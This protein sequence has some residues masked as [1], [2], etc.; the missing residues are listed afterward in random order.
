MKQTNIKVLLLLLLLICYQC[1]ASIMRQTKE[2]HT[3]MHP[4]PSEDEKFSRVKRQE[5]SEEDFHNEYE[6][7]SD[8]WRTEA[9]IKLRKQLL[10]KRNKNVAK[11]V[12]MF[13]GDGMSISTITAARI[14]FGQKLGYRGEES[15]L[16]F[17]EF[18]YVGLSKVNKNKSGAVITQL[19]VTFLSFFVRLTATTSKQLTV[20][21]LQPLILLVSKQT[22]PRSE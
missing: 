9:Q 8:F 17:E 7:T 20:P 2:V 16:S 21:A 22:T 10:K 3:H 18:P 15:V 11:N 5:N 1:K 12:I 14:Y 4:S 6:S 13:I 19:T